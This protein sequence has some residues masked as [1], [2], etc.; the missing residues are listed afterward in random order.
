MRELTPQNRKDID[1]IETA[2]A[3]NSM[4]E[5]AAWEDRLSSNHR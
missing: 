4:L 1:A 2:L 5:P 3:I